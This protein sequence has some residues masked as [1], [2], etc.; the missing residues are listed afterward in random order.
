MLQEK[1]VVIF[2]LKKVVL[3]ISSYGIN[4]RIHHYFAQFNSKPTIFWE[5]NTGDRTLVSRKVGHVDPFFQIPN[6]YHGVLRSGAKD[7]SIRMELS[8]GKSWNIQSSYRYYQQRTF[9]KNQKYLT[10]IHFMDCTMI[11]NYFQQSSHKKNISFSL[12][13]LLCS[14]VYTDL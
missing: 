2:L 6:F 7:K 12:W 10:I 5:S 8:T 11:V 13:S 14:W 3:N 1:S 4:F 9:Y